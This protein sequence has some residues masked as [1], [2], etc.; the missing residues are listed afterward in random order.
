VLPICR[1]LTII[2][3]SS[4]VLDAQARFP[5][6]FLDEVGHLGSDFD[7]RK[8]VEI[9]TATVFPEEGVLRFEGRDR[10][11]SPWHAWVPQTGGIGW[12]EV[13]TADFDRNGQPDLLIASHFPG[14]GRC[15]SP[16]DLFFLL[17]D[18]FGRPVPWHV[19]T[20]IPNG[21]KFP[22][23]PAILLDANRDGRAEIVST[24][25]EYGDQ[26]QGH[27][28]DWSITGVYEAR[29]TRWVPLRTANVAAYIQAATTSNGVNKWLP[30]KPGEWLDSLRAIDAASGTKL[31]RLIPEEERCRH[32]INIPIV[33][34]RVVQ[35]VDDPCD[36]QRYQHASYSDGLTR[37]GWPWVVIDGPHGREIFI[38]NNEDALR[39]VIEKGYRVKLLGDDAEPSWLWAEEAQA[40]IPLP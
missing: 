19:S 4:V 11:G 6:K 33:D 15:E 1:I 16:A 12:T 7:K 13:W 21:T 17:F 10:N 3:A 36:E 32:V 39:R 9:R 8:S 28:T 37:R 31:T 2:A 18:Q 40:V 27:L 5:M 22:Y 25:C 35:P 34:G 23:L 30:V 14:N 24:V 38:A 29:D 26:T 20:E